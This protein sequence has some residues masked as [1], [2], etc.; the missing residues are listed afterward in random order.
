MLEHD[1]L[2][3]AHSVEPLEQIIDKLRH[4]IKNNHIMRLQN[5]ECTVEM[6]FI[7][8]D[9]LTNYERIADHCSNIAVSVLG[10]ANNE[11][12]SHDYLAHIKNDGEHEFF[13]KYNF[14]KQKYRL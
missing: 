9:L 2:E 7:L 1:N 14:Y 6:G 11:F 8:S 3:L 4:V 12:E 13:E 5:G 10:N